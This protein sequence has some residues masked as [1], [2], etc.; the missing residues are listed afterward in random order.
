MALSELAEDDG[1]ADER[2]YATISILTG[3]D[4]D[5]IR[6][7]SMATLADIGNATSFT[8]QPIA[9]KRRDTVRLL[10]RKFRVN[11]NPKK[12]SYGAFA[13]MMHFV[14]DEASAKK[15]LHRAFACCLTERA[16]RW[17]WSPWE[18]NGKDHEAIAEAI[19]D[20]PVTEVKPH[21]DFFL[22]NYL[23]YSRRMAIYLGLVHKAMRRKAAFIKSTAG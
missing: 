14:K 21:T 7:W 5:D 1:S 20:L 16:G 3:A 15:N 6:T 11:A 8:S 19:L 13:D 4:M 10:G 9:G 18:Y 12:L 17:P 2:M 23:R 22:S